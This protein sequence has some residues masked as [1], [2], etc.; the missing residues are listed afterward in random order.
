M[1][2]DEVV[3]QQLVDLLVARQAHMSFADAVENFPEAYIN[4]KP[5]GVDY[6]FWHLL[7]HIRFC[8][9]DILDYICNPNYTAPEFPV[10]LWQG[11]DTKTDKAGWDKSIAD[12]LADRQALVDIINDPATDIYAQIP[13]GQPGHNIIR[14]IHVIA[15][16]NAYHIGELAILRQVMGIW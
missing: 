13:H 14:E 2:N 15:D 7:D 3:R 6:T 9:W 1:T 10:G 16:H 5:L 11:R 12:F 8:Q 4:K